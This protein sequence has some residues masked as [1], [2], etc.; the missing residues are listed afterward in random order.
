MVVC[1]LAVLPPLFNGVR[2]D[3]SICWKQRPVLW[4]WRVYTH[5][6]SGYV[7]STNIPLSIISRCSPSSRHECQYDQS[8]SH[9]PAISWRIAADSGAELVSL[10]PRWLSAREQRLLH[11]VLGEMAGSWRSCWLHR[12]VLDRYDLLNGNSVG[13]LHSNTSVKLLCSYVMTEWP[14]IHLPK[15]SVCEGATICL[16]YLKHMKRWWATN[17]LRSTENNWVWRTPTWRAGRFSGRQ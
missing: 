9:W 12:C 17:R 1:L 8:G 7:H 10:R 11:W 15:T 3:K 2:L 6:S 14:T 13:P 5:P 16:K 4:W